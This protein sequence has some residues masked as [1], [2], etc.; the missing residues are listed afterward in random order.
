[1]EEESKMKQIYYLLLGGIIGVLASLLRPSVTDGDSTLAVFETGVRSLGIT[2]RMSSWL[3][4][5][6]GC[7]NC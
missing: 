3:L 6:I 1:M 4:S 7:I 2:F 5:L